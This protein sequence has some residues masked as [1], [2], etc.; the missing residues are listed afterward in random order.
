MKDT[1]HNLTPEQAARLVHRYQREDDGPWTLARGSGV[2]PPTTTYFAGA[3][4]LMSTARDYLLFES[5]LL[6][7]GTIH[8]KRVLRPESVELMRTNMVGDLYRGTRGDATG[9]GFGVLARVVTDAATSKSGRS[10][11]A[12]GWGGAY[13][14]MSWTDPA[15]QLV[16]AIMIQQPVNAL[17]HDFEMA[18]RGAMTA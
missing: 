15:E 1:R 8:G 2:A 16:A 3:Y 14:T 6:N 10:N 5:M 11:G 17:Q 9:T 13:G 7:K 18:V 4:G 12:F